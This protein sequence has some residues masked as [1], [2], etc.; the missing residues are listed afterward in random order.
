MA[1]STTAIQTQITNM[2]AQLATQQFLLLSVG[3]DNTSV[4]NQR[5]DTINTLLNKLY[6]QLDV[7]T[8]GRIVRGVVH[9]F[10]RNT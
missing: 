5:I 9:G 10:G 8:N 2:E 4:V 3:S 1:R 7:I 6:F